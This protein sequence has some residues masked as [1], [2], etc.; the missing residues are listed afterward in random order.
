MQD[1][2]LLAPALADSRTPFPARLQ[3]CLSLLLERLGAERGMV[4]TCSPSGE[5]LRIQACVPSHLMGEETAAL[6]CA[7]Q[8][9]ITAEPDPLLLWDAR[10]GQEEHPLIYGEEINPSLI[11]SPMF[12]DLD[13]SLI[14][15]VHIA[16]PLHGSVFT[17]HDLH[18]LTSCCKLLAP[19]L[20]EFLRQETGQDNPSREPEH[21]ASDDASA[22][23]TN[24]DK[25]GMLEMVIH[26]LKSPLSALITNL[27]LLL[28]MS[29]SE[30][31]ASL[32]R[33][34]IQSANKF[35]LRITQVLELS[36]L[37]NFSVKDTTL[38]PVDLEQAVSRQIQEHQ[39]LLE[40][41]ELQIHTNAPPEVSV[42]AEDS[43]LNHLLQNLI[44]NAIRHTPP[45]GSIT[46][47]W[48]KH[49]AMRKK[50]I[51]PNV[52]LVCIQ[53]TGE[54][55]SEQKKQEL[56]HSIRLG[57]SSYF[58]KR[59]GGMGLVICSRILD[60]LQGDLWIEDASPLGTRV[61]FTL[62]GLDDGH[63]DA[64]TSPE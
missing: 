26:D 8:Q 22:V 9:K 62:P 27:D 12:S 37:Q 7:A 48:D 53:D 15:A 51:S 19:F 11:V 25:S 23:F 29:N 40:Q 20:A 60:I 33:T 13:G 56:M 52:V 42:L 24:A 50:D 43:L 14:G 3:Q 57:Q 5:S 49:R 44:S 35:Y 34:A 1:I 59:G 38:Q 30:K 36:R 46:L 2:S 61:C 18:R 47:S 21:A 10:Q 58:G 54:G 39:T 17:E 41:K 16:G 63:Y 28:G 4:L 64:Q 32:L 31:Q 55:I 6:S 45:Q